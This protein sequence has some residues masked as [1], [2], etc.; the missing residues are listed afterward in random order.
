MFTIIGIL[1]VTAGKTAAAV[2]ALLKADRQPPGI[3][4]NRIPDMSRIIG[5]VG[6]MTCPAGAPFDRLIDM[7]EMQILIAITEGGQRGGFLIAGERFFMTHETELVI[8]RVIPGI[9]LRGEILTQYSKVIR[10]MGVVASGTVFLFDRAVY[11]GVS[12]E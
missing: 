4:G 9:E 7:N 3:E 5:G 1:F 8:V 12:F 2:N 6:I 10:S 11:H